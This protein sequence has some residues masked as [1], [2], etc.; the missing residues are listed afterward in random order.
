MVRCWA[1]GERGLSP[2][3]RG[4]HKIREKQNQQIGS[5]PACAGETV[6]GGDPTG[7]DEVYPRV[8]G[9]NTSGSYTRAGIPGL[10]PRVR[11]KRLLQPLLAPAGRSIP[12]CA[13]ETLARAKPRRLTMVY[14]RVCGGN[15][16]AMP[17]GASGVGLSPRVRG[18]R[19][20]L[21]LHPPLLRSIPACAG[22]TIWVRY[23]CGV[24]WVYP[25]VCG[26]NYA[27]AGRAVSDGGLSPRVRGKPLMSV[28]LQS[29]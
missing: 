24:G 14:P 5:I 8:C 9:G 25:R 29:G 13:G 16:C 7:L 3:V 6:T 12:A 27:G 2:R 1:C 17:Y 18:K 20:F 15:R 22:E 26:G 11:G 28:G 4:K 23:W 21:R 10:S 19:V